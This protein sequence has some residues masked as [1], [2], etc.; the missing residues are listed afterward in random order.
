[1][2]ADFELGGR[3]AELRGRY[4][5]AGAEA[6]LRAVLT[7]EFS[8]RVAVVSSFGAESAV[9]LH[10]VASIDPATPVLFLDTGNIF[11]ETLRYRD[12]LVG[13]L[14]LSDVRSIRPD[15]EEEARADPD[16]DL[17]KR[18]PDTCCYVRKVLPLRRA[19]QAFEAEISGRKR[20][21]TPAR[22][23]MRTIEP[24]EGRIK[25]N[26]LADYTLGAL[27]GYIAR[28]GLPRHPLVD[29]GYLSLGCI[30][31]TERAPRDGDYRAGRWP[32]RLKDECG[33][34]TL[35]RRPLPTS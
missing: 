20:F 12:T 31:C 4:E 28:H 26:P 33:I 10:M 22:S 16:G 18:D 24:S 9:L 27:H 3:L 1:M 32:G 23:K 15:P 8:G 17:W 11:G 21:Q 30:P 19:L 5:K 6:L 35:P 13:T 29:A 7:V 14:G 25:I 2:A 34:H